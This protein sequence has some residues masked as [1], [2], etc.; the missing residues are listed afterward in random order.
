[1]WCK[2]RKVDRLRWY[3]CSDYCCLKY[4]YRYFVHTIFSLYLKYALNSITRSNWFYDGKFHCKTG[5]RWRMLVKYWVWTIIEFS[6]VIESP[7]FHLQFIRSQILCVGKLAVKTPR[8]TWH[9]TLP[10]YAES[11]TTQW[12]L[13]L[14]GWTIKSYRETILSSVTVWELCTLIPASNLPPCTLANNLWVPS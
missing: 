13:A 14:N 4:N 3:Y 6:L 5:Q 10:I 1:M 9:M 12:P 7:S 2:G 8:P 11:M